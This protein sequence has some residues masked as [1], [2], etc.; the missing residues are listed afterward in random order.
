MES[1][2]KVQ[3]SPLKLLRNWVNFKF[4]I[5]NVELDKTY[6]QHPTHDLN[7]QP[8]LEAVNVSH[9][10]DYPL[11]ENLNLYLFSGQSIAIIG[12]SGSGK[13]TFLNILSTLL[14]PNNGNVIFDNQNVYSLD[15]DELLEI[16]KNDF[17]IIFQSH[18]LFRGFNAREN[19]EIAELISNKTINSDILDSFKIEHVL[20]QNIG[21]LSGGQQ[22]R[23]SI[24]R[25][26]AKYPRIIFADEPTGNLDMATALDVMDVLFNY[27]KATNGALVLVTHEDELAEK[28]DIVY[29]LEDFRL[30][31]LKGEI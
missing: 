4:L 5:M 20:H 31:K 23:V 2:N 12:A 27:V 29:K 3:I 17:G 30:K 22:Q 11:F 13:S 1:K 24:A 10:F 28:C 8:I 14:K 6:I 16:R 19:I 15:E 7:S 21:E 9:G 25:V 26:L 18:Y